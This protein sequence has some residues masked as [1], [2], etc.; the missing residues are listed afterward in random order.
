MLHPP[1]NDLQKRCNLTGEVELVDISLLARQI[2]DAQHDVAFRLAPVLADL[3]S[4]IV[5]PAGI[6]VFL[7]GGGATVKTLGFQ[8]RV[9]NGARL[10]MYNLSLVE[11]TKSAIQVGWSYI[12][13]SPVYGTVFEP[14]ANSMLD[15]AWV[16]ISNMKTSSEGAALSIDGNATVTIFKVHTFCA[17]L[18]PLS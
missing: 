18:F 3:Q 16:S 4:D 8:F 15:M 13:I 9:E 2:R 11:G 17:C 5:I 6:S 12:H 10:C 14:A 1:T 7:D